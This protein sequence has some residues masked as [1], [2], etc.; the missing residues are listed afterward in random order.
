MRRGLSAAKRGHMKFA[1]TISWCILCLTIGMSGCHYSTTKRAGIPDAQEVL[2]EAAMPMTTRSAAAPAT[3]MSITQ[4]LPRM[5]MPMAAGTR[6]GRQKF[7]TESYDRVIE[8]PFLN[9]LD[10]PLST[11]STDVD[12]ASYAN[13]R[14]FLL[15]EHALP[16]ADAVRTE[17]LL[18]YFTYDYPAPGES[19]PI[20]WTTELVD[21]PWN[22]G[23]KLL[24]L[25][26]QAR[27]IETANL[28]PSNLVFLVDVSGS[29]DEPNKLPLVKTSL[30]MLIDQLRPR[31]R[32]A[33][34]VYAGAAGVA[35]PSTPGSEKRTI[36]DALDALE[37]GGSTAGGEGIR[38]AY[39]IAREHFLTTGN[40]RV[41]LATDGDFNVG[42]SS[43]AEMERLIE[44]KRKEGVFLS[45]LG[46]GMGNYKDSKMQKLA[47]RGNGNYAYI[48]SLLEARKVLVQ[49]M[50]GTLQTVARDVKVQIEFNPAKV[51]RH[52]LIGYEKRLLRSRDFDDDTRD[53]GEMGAGHSVTVLYEIEPTRSGAAQKAT[54][55]K[56]QKKHITE[57]AKKGTILAWAR[58]R[59]KEPAGEKS[60][61]IEA[62]VKYE[63]RTLEQGSTNIR[64]AAAVAEWCMLLRSSEHKGTASFDQVLAAARSAKGSDEEGYRAEFLQLVELSQML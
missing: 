20:A 4:P 9:A 39:K 17:E 54:E 36:A 58:F 59:Y 62:P 24:L 47:D 1:K 55:L 35:L 7:N 33:I 53:A 52:R 34:V 21:C 50:G 12:T 8:N 51:G 10:E 16:P 57:D 11:F 27:R 44:E 32:V 42:A 43:D 37:A 46:F 48:D 30:K 60:S 45:V 6:S 29:M 19:E 38:L 23:N 5:T 18:N 61:L 63:P 49:Q 14:R 31:D 15:R 64:F 3:R 13:V 26:L 2:T 40:N 22:P 41:I 28:P 25:G 56:F